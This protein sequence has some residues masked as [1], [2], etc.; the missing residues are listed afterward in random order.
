MAAIDWL[1]AFIGGPMNAPA[2]ILLLIIAATLVLEDAA[3]VAVG[4][5]AAHGSVSVELALAGL[6]IGTI[7]GDFALHLI[8]RWAAQ[9]RYTAKLRQRPR[10]AQTEAWL[11]R[12]PLS[13]LALARFVPGLRLP[14][15]LASGVLRFPMYRTLAVLTLVTLIWT[16]ALFWL[17]HSIMIAAETIGL[18]GWLMA[19]LLMVAALMAPRIAGRFL[20]AQPA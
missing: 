8:G 13:A 17:S 10:V 19:A 3:T 12:R 18:I 7:I 5:L 2:T 4:M 16:P 15:F 6:V 1:T 11:Q 20:K 9:S 14:T